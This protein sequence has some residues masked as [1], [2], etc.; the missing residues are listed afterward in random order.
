[1]NGFWS[2]VKSFDQQITLALN[3]GHSEYWNS[4]MST[5]T[6]K[7][8]WIPILLTIVYVLYKNNERRNFLLIILSVILCVTFADQISSSIFKPLFQRF[9]PSHDPILKYQIELVNNYRGG[10]YGFISSHAANCFSIATFLMLLF[11]NKIMTIVLAFWAVLICYTRIYMGVHF[12]GDILAGAL[13]GAIIGFVIYR[14]YSRI[15]LKC[16]VF[17]NESLVGQGKITYKYLFLIYIMLGV[18]YSF[19]FVKAFF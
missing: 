17:R 11:R 9:R 19:I 8:V 13:T 6:S 3:G 5:L 16:P 10:R 14:C 15:L 4:V 1:M 18:T 2:Q 7:Y 12:L